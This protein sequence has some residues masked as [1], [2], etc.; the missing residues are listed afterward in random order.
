LLSVF[1]EL[2]LGPL[3]LELCSSEEL[4]GNSSA[5]EDEGVYTLELPGFG[6]LLELKLGLEGLGSGGI[7][8]EL[9]SSWSPQKTSNKLSLPSLHPETAITKATATKNKR[10][11]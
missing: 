9:D 11:I 7:P 10:I 6:A 3:E 4:E 2:D 1:E 5:V 8:L